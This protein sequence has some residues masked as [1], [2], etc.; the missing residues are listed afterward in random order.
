M[1]EDGGVYGL[2]RAFQMAGARTVV[3]ALWPVSDEAT[4]EMMGNL[5]TALKG[6]D[7]I[8]LAAAIE[9]ISLGMR[10]GGTAIVEE[11]LVFPVPRIPENHYCTGLVNMPVDSGASRSHVKRSEATTTMS[12]TS[13]TA[14]WG[15]S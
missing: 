7:R 8:C 14:S 3:S 4:A 13:V 11:R 9:K 5:V 1:A 15:C 10:T 12:S 6:A 2:R